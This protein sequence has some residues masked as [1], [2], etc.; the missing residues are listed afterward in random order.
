M[1]HGVKGAKAPGGNNAPKER[2]EVT[3]WS[4]SSSRRNRDFLMSVD[5]DRLEGVGVAFTLTIRDLPETHSE[6]EAIRRR[7]VERLR[8]T[9]M[10]RLH[11][12]T[13]FQRRGAPHLHGIA[14]F[15]ASRASDRMDLGVIHMW[16]Q[17]TDHLR[18]S[19]RAQH[20]A[21]ISDI[22]GWMIYLGKHASR[23]VTHYQR[24]KGA[25]PKG[26]QKTGRMWGK[27]GEW[28][29]TSH[30]WNVTDDAFFRFRRSVRGYLL[31]Q[32]RSE[33]RVARTIRDPR[34]RAHGVAQALRRIRYLRRR[35]KANTRQASELRG[36]TDWLNPEFVYLWMICEMSLDQE[37]VEDW[38]ED[39]EA[40]R[41]ARPAPH[42]QHLFAK[43]SAPR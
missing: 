24:A 23:S 19:E 33:L 11:W 14:Y 2:G 34:K 16:M 1:P 22:R 41:P 8:R 36:F 40:R 26:W 9:G 12:L 43:V 27:S 10:I 29:E 31:A 3:G 32:A 38:R 30:S 4:S 15:P 25:L 37:T 18:P 39:P 5:P 28:P 6:W 35:L 13:E 17:C 42:P 7:F 20:A 21:K